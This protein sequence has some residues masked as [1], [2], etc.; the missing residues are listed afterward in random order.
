MA[1][2]N[3]ARFI[4]WDDGWMLES[5]GG[6]SVQNWAVQ[7]LGSMLKDVRRHAASCFGA[8]VVQL[9]KAKFCKDETGKPFL[10]GVVSIA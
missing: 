3:V 4:V 1:T 9:G 6:G 8:H 7:P 2:K 10:A 5:F